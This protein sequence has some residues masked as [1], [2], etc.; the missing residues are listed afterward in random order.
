MTPLSAFPVAHLQFAGTVTLLCVNWHSKLC[1][2]WLPPHSRPS[3]VLKAE[4]QTPKPPHLSEHP[5][6][7]MAVH[8]PVQASRKHAPSMAT[9]RT[10]KCR[11]Q[12]TCRKTMLWSPQSLRFRLEFAQRQLTEPIQGF[13]AASHRQLQVPIKSQKAVNQS[14]GKISVP[15]PVLFLYFIIYSTLWF[16]ATF[17]LEKKLFSLSENWYKKK[18]ISQP[19]FLLMMFTSADGEKITF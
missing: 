14:P 12:G 7:S 3:R 19:S 6:G 13:A 11:G 16:P 4:K 5:L 10:N 8:D 2:N 9:G 18:S 1:V 17:L 15:S